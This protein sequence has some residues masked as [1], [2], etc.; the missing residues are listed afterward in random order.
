MAPPVHVDVA[1]CTLQHSTYVCMFQ[2]TS[3][4]TFEYTRV[5]SGIHGSVP[6]YFR[7][8]GK[9]EK[10]SGMT[11]IDKPEEESSREY[12]HAAVLREAFNA[13]CMRPAARLCG[14][15]PIYSRSG[16]RHTSMS[17]ESS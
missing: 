15:D 4:C 6:T 7:N 5:P 13:K 11:P 17:P 2:H 10:Q 12:I 8:S 9:H 14:R 16:F 1:E 3:L